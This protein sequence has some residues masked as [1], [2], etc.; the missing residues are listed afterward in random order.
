M[1]TIIVLIAISIVVAVA[2][3][4][5]QVFQYRRYE[6]QRK[7]ARRAAAGLNVY[8]DPAREIRK[9]QEAGFSVECALAIMS[10]VASMKGID[11]GH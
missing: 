2:F 7:A 6:K 9:L 8:Y 11:E 5:F 1:T 10:C 3:L 4:A